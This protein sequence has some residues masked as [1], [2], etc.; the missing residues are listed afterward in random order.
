MRYK[1]DGYESGCIVIFHPKTRRRKKKGRGEKV[2]LV[3]TVIRYLYRDVCT[4]ISSIA[5][6]RQ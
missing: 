2:T 1:K 4:E 3:S 6:I 5:L